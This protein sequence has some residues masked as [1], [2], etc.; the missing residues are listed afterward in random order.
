MAGAHAG[1]TPAAD[2]R[3]AFV[4][5]SLTNDRHEPTHPTAGTFNRARRRTRGRSANRHRLPSRAFRRSIANRHDGSRGTETTPS[6]EGAATD[7]AI[8][9]TALLHGHQGR[10]F[11]SARTGAGPIRATR[12]KLTQGTPG[13]RPTTPKAMT[14]TSGSFPIWVCMKW[15]EREKTM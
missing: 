6:G 1:L 13:K 12:E 7:F 5:L 14:V 9:R 3:F 10:R 11:V 4:A 2:L 8:A 15:A